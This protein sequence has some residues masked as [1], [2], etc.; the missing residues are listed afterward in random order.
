[1]NP[2]LPQ[3]VLSV[4]M[5][6]PKLNRERVGK[7]ALELYFSIYLS[8]F[9]SLKSP[10]SSMAGTRQGNSRCAVFIPSPLEGFPQPSSHLYSTEF[11]H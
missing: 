2:F 9:P 1:M 6:A 5:L 8:R 11:N 7:M 4:G 10:S 3:G